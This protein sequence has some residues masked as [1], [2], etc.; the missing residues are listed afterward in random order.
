VLVNAVSADAL[1]QVAGRVLGERVVAVG[2]SQEAQLAALEAPGGPVLTLGGDRGAELVPISVAR[3]RYGSGLVVAW[4]DVGTGTVLESLRGEGDAGS[5]AS[6][7][8]EPGHAR[9]LG[10]DLTLPAMAETLRGAECVYVHV[11]L[12]VADPG[13]AGAIGTLRGVNVVGAGVTEGA[14]RHPD[15]GPVLA[16]L[17]ELLRSPPAG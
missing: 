6:P 1:G 5:A 17:G 12:D 3:F 7:A 4:L 10:A 16:A 8:L 9:V 11:G 13:L 2:A 14:G 15:P